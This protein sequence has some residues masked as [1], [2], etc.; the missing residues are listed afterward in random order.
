MNTITN[1]E[2]SICSATTTAGRPF[3]SSS[4][5]LLFFFSPPRP[6]ICL[7]RLLVPA[8]ARIQLDPPTTATRDTATVAEDA[9]TTTKSAVGGRR[10]G[11]EGD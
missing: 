9:V 6:T 11:E 1:H 4:L 8:V 2:S 7:L 5:P 10:E 3:T